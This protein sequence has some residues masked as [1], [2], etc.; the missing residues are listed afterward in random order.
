MMDVWL[1]FFNFIAFSK[2]YPPGDFV[3]LSWSHSQILTTAMQVLSINGVSATWEELIS[4]RRVRVGTPQQ[5]A[6]HFAIETGLPLTAPWPETSMG[7]W[8]NSP[9]HWLTGEFTSK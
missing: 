6:L 5:I 9:H 3:L 1:S 2:Q 7:N 8:K 4:F